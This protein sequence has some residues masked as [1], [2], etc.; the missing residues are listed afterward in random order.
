MTHE[1]VKPVEKDPE[2]KLLS[3]S[4]QAEARRTLAR[5]IK[6][7]RGWSDNDPEWRALQA[8]EA[9][10]D[11]RSR[12]QAEENERRVQEIEQQIRR[13]TKLREQERQRQQELR[14]GR[15]VGCLV[16]TTVQL[17]ELKKKLDEMEKLAEAE[18]DSAETEAALLERLKRQ[19]EEERRKRDQAVAEVKKQR[20]GLFRAPRL[21]LS[22]KG[23]KK[24]AFAAR[25]KLCCSS[26]AWRQS[27]GWPSWSGI[28]SVAEYSLG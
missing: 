19:R 23:M 16:L 4:S 5:S 11:E 15:P 3:V 17:A 27:S 25:S 2:E 8:K 1:Q 7:Q 24:S 21:M 14:V 10:E 18:D 26:A 20:Y 13:K 22:D 9:A 6:L 28:L 12:R